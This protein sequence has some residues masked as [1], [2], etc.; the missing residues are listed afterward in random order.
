MGEEQLVPEEA[1]WITEEFFPWS[2]ESVLRHVVKSKSS[3]RTEQPV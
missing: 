2:R 1:M 3:C